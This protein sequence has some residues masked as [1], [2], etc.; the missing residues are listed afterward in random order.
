MQTSILLSVSIGATVSS[1]YS[2]AQERN[3]LLGSQ[4]VE[5]VAAETPSDSVIDTDPIKNYSG[6]A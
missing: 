1:G 5:P 2:E 4:S 3:M 6:E